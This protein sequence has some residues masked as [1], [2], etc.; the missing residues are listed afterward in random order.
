MLLCIRHAE[1]LRAKD[2]SR[3]VELFVFHQEEAFSTDGFIGTLNWLHSHT[4]DGESDVLADQVGVWAQLDEVGV[5]VPVPKLTDEPL[6]DHLLVCRL[7]VSDLQSW[8]PWDGTAGARH[9]HLRSRIVRLVGLLGR[10]L[11]CCRYLL[12]LFHDLDTL[13]QPLRSFVSFVHLEQVAIHLR[14]VLIDELVDDLRWQVD[15]DVEDSVFLCPLEGLN[16]IFLDIGND[17][18]GPSE[19]VLVPISVR[20]T[21]IGAL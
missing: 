13:G 4:E 15:P 9:G 14:E 21:I 2:A 7:V 5:D 3:S 6:F 8:F 10:W 1:D 17:R 12:K 11:R 18:M 19:V 20:L 16:K